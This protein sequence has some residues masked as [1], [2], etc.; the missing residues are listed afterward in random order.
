M[1][2]INAGGFREKLSTMAPYQLD[3]PAYCTVIRFLAMVVKNGV[4]LAS[5]LIIIF[6]YLNFS[7]LL[8]R[9]APQLNAFLL[10]LMVKSLI[11]FLLL[12]LYFTPILPDRIMDL[13]LYPVYLLGW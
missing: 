3:M 8:A 7:G 6:C 12:L 2:T 4:I 1:A 11:G 13:R 10:A 9:F 5:P